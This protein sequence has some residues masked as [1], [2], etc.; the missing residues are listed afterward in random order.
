MLRA[1]PEGSTVEGPVI[2]TL[3]V[4]TP[5]YPN[6]LGTSSKLVQN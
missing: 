1:E 3:I 6:R 5:N 4:W 2:R